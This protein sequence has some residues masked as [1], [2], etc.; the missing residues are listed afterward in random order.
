MIQATFVLLKGIGETTEHR[1]WQSG[2]EH[3]DTFRASPAL[4]GISGERK[5]SYDAELAVATRQLQ[6]GNS[7]Y[8]ACCLKPRDHW[9][10]YEA[11]RARA[12]FLDIETT[13]GSPDFGEVTVVGLFANGQMTS[14]VRGEG[15]T[16]SRLNRELARCDLL[17]TFCGS[18]FD[19]PYLRAKFPGLALNQPHLD[20]CFAARRLGLTGGLKRIESLVGIHR[21]VELEGLDGWDAVRLWNL[22]RRGDTAALELLRAYNE[23]DTRS[24][25][26]LTDL[27]YRRLVERYRSRFGR[28]GRET[29]E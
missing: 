24:L 22:W 9:R 8:F 15:L 1:L 6:E 28:I 3:W 23:H 4:P 12:T 13:G 7:R 14:L 25:E 27:V 17:V 21:P 16:Q 26:P 10:L 20:L 29:I 11:F 5:R 18:L 19:L 2:I